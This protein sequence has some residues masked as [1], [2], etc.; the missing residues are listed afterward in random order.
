MKA[1]S[2]LAYY[3]D[4]NSIK[5]VINILI[6]FTIIFIFKLIFDVIYKGNQAFKIIPKFIKMYQ[7]NT[8]NYK[9]LLFTKYILYVIVFMDLLSYFHQTKFM[10]A[11]Y[12]S[13]RSV[14]FH[15]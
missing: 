8:I 15:L 12:I 14:L 13:Y 7:S 5:I 2:A 4:N 3:L 10:I 11:I 6:I 9:F 1:R